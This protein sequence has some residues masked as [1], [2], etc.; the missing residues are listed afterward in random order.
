MSA[1]FKF[2]KKESIPI[3]V[4]PVK[5]NIGELY[6]GVAKA[7]DVK[8]ICSADER[9]Y[10]PDDL[11]KYL[12]M[13]RTL[14]KKRVKEIK[15]YLK[16]KDATFPNSIILSLKNGVFFIEGNILYVKKDKSSANIIDGQHRLAGFDENRQRD[17]E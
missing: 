7:S 4:L 13:Q 9:R 14:S 17:F 3:K 5:Q 6:V 12:G 8:K 11:E 15:D 16:T 1:P 2:T 10:N